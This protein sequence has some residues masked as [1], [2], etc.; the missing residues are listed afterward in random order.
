MGKRGSGPCLCDD[1]LLLPKSSILWGCAV[2][3][4]IYGFLIVSRY[5]APFGQLKQAV[6]RVR[7]HHRF[8]LG[9]YH[10]VVPNESRVLSSVLCWCLLDL[11]CRRWT[12]DSG[13][14][15]Q[16]YEALGVFCFGEQSLSV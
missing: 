4:D 8:L 12:G 15:K 10:I 2:V 11:Y 5:L 1:G 9:L 14:R 3:T 7:A 16:K 6:A 13:Y